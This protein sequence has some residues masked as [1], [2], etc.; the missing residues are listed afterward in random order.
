[1]VPPY[2][3]PPR[4]TREDGAPRRVGVEVEFAGLDVDEAIGIVSELWGGRVVPRSR[5][6]AVVVGTRLGD[7]RVEVDSQ[8][9]LERRYVSFVERL[10]FGPKAQLAVEDAV[11]AIARRWIPCEIVAPPVELDRLPQLESLREALH[12]RHARGTKASLFFGF[13]FQLNAE[14]PSLE[15]DS[16]LRHLQAFLLLYE[17]LAAECAVDLTRRIGPFVQP[18]PESY[19]RKVLAAGYHP[20]LDAF[21]GDY[22]E[23]NPTRNRPLDLLPIFATFDPERVERSVS[24]ARKVSA[25]PAFH[26]RLPNSMVDDPEWSFAMEWNRWC[27]VEDLAE[28]RHRLTELAAAFRSQIVDEGQLD[29][30]TWARTVDATLA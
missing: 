17:W 3:R 6:E 19:R 22:L 1:M 5:F 26:Y 27:E 13:A 20:D 18:F 7:F 2:R 24:N 11:G 15:V 14:V 25:R 30:D 21:I 23:A 29:A 4:T 10:G 12:A 9:V 16:L 28:D 8:P